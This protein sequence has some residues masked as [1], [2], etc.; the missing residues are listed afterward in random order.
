MIAT[1]S[2]HGLTVYDASVGSECRTLAH[3]RLGNRSTIPIGETAL[4]RV[5]YSTDSRVLLS[6]WKDGFRLWDAQ[7]GVELYHLSDAHSTN[8]AFSPDGA[9]LVTQGMRGLRL[10]PITY[11]A[12]G[13]DEAMVLGPPKLIEQASEGI[14]YV[15]W[16]RAG[17]ALGLTLGDLQRFTVVDPGFPSQRKWVGSQTN[18]N[19]LALSPDGRWLATGTWQPTTVKIWEA[20]NGRFVRELTERSHY[21]VFSPDGRWLG[22]H[23]RGGYRL[24]EVGTWKPGPSIPMDWDTGRLA[25][26]P[27]SRLLAFLDKRTDLVKLYEIDH[28]KVV[29]TL[30]PPD[31]AGVRSL[32]FSP[33]GRQLAVSTEEH[34]VQVWNLHAIRARLRPLGLDWNAP[35]YADPAHPSSPPPQKPR[36]KLSALIENR[37][38]SFRPA[39][40]RSQESG[41]R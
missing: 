2:S 31:R 16:D 34:T 25:F 37:G 14:Q 4:G 17:T 9:R 8:V 36:I 3:A 5:T 20:R 10:W 24:F 11:G 26:S 29:A 21:P 19:E 28:R 35:A 33:D 27:D 15:S 1:A 23:E 30:D 12:T 18:V 7:T 41:E 39:D 13:D 38:D 32:T 40:V 6:A 22:V